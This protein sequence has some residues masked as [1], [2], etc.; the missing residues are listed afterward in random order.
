M[1]DGFTFTGSTQN[2]DDD[3][4]VLVN[5]SE[6]DRFVLID[7]MD[8][9][10]HTIMPEFQQRVESG[11]LFSPTTYPPQMAGEKRVVATDENMD[12]VERPAGREDYPEMKQETPILASPYMYGGL[13]KPVPS[14]QRPEGE[15]GLLEETGR[16]LAAGAADV[17][18]S[19]GMGLQATGRFLEQANEPTV[20]YET[21]QE[22][23]GIPV[24]GN[25]LS[26]VGEY[27]K[28]TGADTS[29]YWAKQGEKFPQSTDIQGDIVRNPDLLG[30]PKW[31]ASSVARMTPGMAAAVM[32]SVASGGVANLAGLQTA[33][34]GLSGAI[35]GGIAGGLLEG[36][37]TRREALE[38]GMNE[39][40]AIDAGAKMTVASGLLNAISLNS[41]LNTQA[42]NNLGKFLLSGSVEALTEYGEE[43][44]EGTILNEDWETFKERLIRG[45]SVMPPSFLVGG[46]TGMGAQVSGGDG[47]AAKVSPQITPTPE[48]TFNAVGAVREEPV[49]QP[50]EVA[51][52]QE[53]APQPVAPVPSI[54]DDELLTTEGGRTIVE[55]R[56]QLRNRLATEQEKQTADKLFERGFTPALVSHM[57]NTLREDTAQ[58]NTDVNSFLESHPYFMDNP[59]VSVS[60]NEERMVRAEQELTRREAEQER[61]KQEET[62]R[63]KE[64]KAKPVEKP[65]VQEQPPVKP[66][67]PITD[68]ARYGKDGRFY[69]TPDLLNDMPATD[70]LSGYGALAPGGFKVRLIDGSKPQRFDVIQRT[71]GNAEIQVLNNVTRKRANQFINEQGGNKFYG[72][73][74]D[75][76]GNVYLG[77][78]K[79]LI[80]K[81]EWSTGI[82]DDA[83]QRYNEIADERGL[84]RANDISDL[85]EISSDEMEPLYRGMTQQEWQSIKESGYTREQLQEMED[86]YKSTKQRFAD[87]GYT[88]DDLAAIDAEYGAENVAQLRRDEATGI[89]EADEGFTAGLGELASEEDIAKWERESEILNAEEGISPED[90]TRFTQGEQVEGIISKEPEQPRYA[91]SA[92][93]DSWQRSY[94]MFDMADSLNGQTIKAGS[95]IYV[96]DM[97]ARILSPESYDSLMQNPQRQAQYEAEYNQRN[98]EESDAAKRQ[99]KQ[100]NIDPDQIDMFGSGTQERIAYSTTVEYNNT[101]SGGTV[102]L[103]M[104]KALRKDADEYGTTPDGGYYFV[105][106]NK[107]VKIYGVKFINPNKM[108]FTAEYGREYNPETDKITAATHNG[109]I[110]LTRE[111]GIWGAQKELYHLLKEMGLITDADTK[112]VRKSVAK[113]YGKN[114]NDVTINDEGE[115]VK[116]ALRRRAFQRKTV[117]GKILQKIQD[118]ISGLANI[119]RKTA[120]GIVRSIESGNVFSRDIDTANAMVNYMRADEAWEQED[121][122]I[123]SNINKLLDEIDRNATEDQARAIRGWARVE[124][125]TTPLSTIVL[126]HSR[127]VYSK[128][129]NYEDGEKKSIM[130][131][132]VRMLPMIANYMTMSKED[133][134]KFMYATFNRGRDAE[135]NALLDKYNAHEEYKLYRRVLDEIYDK[136]VALGFNIGYIDFY[137]PRMVKDLAKYMDYLYDSPYKNEI[138]EAIKAENKRRVAVYNDAMRKYEYKLEDA[139]R[140]GKEKPAK[141]QRPKSLTRSEEYKIANNVVRGY[142]GRITT[143]GPGNVKS[144]TVDVV[145]ENNIQFYHDFVENTFRYITRM[146]RAMEVKKFFGKHLDAKEVNDIDSPIDDT[147]IP[148]DVLDDSIG[149]LLLDLSETL[150]PESVN[151]LKDLIAIRFNYQTTPAWLQKMKAFGYMSAMGKGLGTALSQVADLSTSFYMGGIKNA[152][153]EFLDA[154]IRNVVKDYSSTF[155]PKF[156]NDPVLRKKMNDAI[157]E[158]F[159]IFGETAGFTLETQ[160]IEAYGSEFRDSETANKWLE[161]MFTVNFLHALDVT[162]KEA[163]MNA[164]YKSYVQ[165]AKSGK[166]KRRHAKILSDAFGGNRE[167]INQ[168]IEDLKSG[169]KTDAVSYLMSTTLANFQPSWLSET[170]PEYL[171]NPRGRAFYSLKTFLI[172]QVDVIRRQSTGDI[173]RGIRL[174]GNKNYEEGGK[175]FARG[176]VRLI[177]IYGFMVAAGAGVDTIRDLLYGRIKSFGDLKREVS[178]NII[179]NMLRFVLLNRYILERAKQ[180]GIAMTAFRMVSLPVDFLEKPARDVYNS[181]EGYFEWRNAV[182]EGKFPRRDKWSPLY[183]KNIIP[184][185]GDMFNVKSGRG[186]EYAL[187]SR[188]DLIKKQSTEKLLHK[189]IEE[190]DFFDNIKI[191]IRKGYISRDDVLKNVKQY[192]ETQNVMRGL[193]KQPMISKETI[194][195]WADDIITEFK[196]ALKTYEE[197]DIKLIYEDKDMQLLVKQAANL[198]NDNQ[199]FD[200]E[201]L[202]YIKTMIEKQNN[203][204]DNYLK[205]QLTAKQINELAD[206]YMK[207]RKEQK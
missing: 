113:I 198:V 87:E 150:R 181:I 60:I 59:D 65:V 114:I 96:N 42:W 13:N 186:G 178:D 118:F 93:N 62:Q 24:V 195:G 155:V 20:D 191:L 35:T 30:N 172:K 41:A 205:P 54:T 149:A 128:M 78:T 48:E 110:F 100:R 122:E 167:E 26:R 83:V 53:P 14:R 143:A 49:V 15:Y 56:T 37:Q 176:L 141:P 129:M 112:A 125:M 159:K 117:I 61:I 73:L 180:D 171:R 11:N 177:H 134:V 94:A 40:E 21:G 206:L 202:D 18:G 204:R 196:G 102:T 153:P 103:D 139:K 156:R 183:I 23:G 17:G 170:T 71:E 38:R 188:L 146:N 2:T 50:Q 75:K 116:N 32:T 187:V 105:K 163:L 97:D 76:L 109:V 45:V 28:G 22:V 80:S 174:M 106:N 47:G 142:G 126:R 135:R 158:Q 55:Q 131:D 79:P 64:E 151:R 121:V 120:E 6:D 101:D 130:R 58:S 165:Q 19:V 111:G 77:V 91:R 166:W 138:L 43:P 10:R 92:Y 16:Q 9:V 63:A 88:D 12:T 98:K 185:F 173:M 119:G 193:A 197:K 68:K 144:R 67:V 66:E 147:P 7:P 74:S 154:A 133:R 115:F 162:G 182:K 4:F 51:T 72:E 136:A 107:V 44:A 104:V 85:M 8:E 33:G 201:A 39:N 137:S 127:E 81:N 190:K 199:M 34:V 145:D 99:F 5:P 207:V 57:S 108:A 25:M 95:P 46:I 31:W 27:L 152:T 70:V 3:R 179:D 192:I 69:I 157:D 123:R 160:G 200:G 84:P 90:V 52:P 169:K 132:N 1:A 164:S 29:E 184:I 89:R 175:Q 148:R 203:L 161:T 82:E 124:D 36:E 168:V 86:E 194:N 140:N 189:P